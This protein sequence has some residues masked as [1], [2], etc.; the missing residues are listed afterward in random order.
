M[1]FPTARLLTVLELLQSRPEITAS[2]LSRALE[3]N[4]RSIR[5][6][7]TMLQDMGIPVEATRG[8]YGGYH[9]E[10]GFKLPPLMFSDAEV[11]ALTLGLIVIRE[12]QF[13]TDVAAITGALAKLERVMPEKLLD[14]THGLQKS[15]MVNL[16]L[17]QT[18]VN[19]TFIIGLSDAMQHCQR[20]RMMYSSW[21]NNISERLF[22]CYGIVYHEGYWFTTGFCHLR[23]GLRTFRIDRITHLE[24]IDVSY[25]R[26]VDFDATAYVIQSLSNTPGHGSIEVLLK[27]SLAQ[28]QKEVPPEIGT[29]EVVEDGVL[30]RR[31]AQNLEYIARMLIDLSFPIQ[32]IQPAELFDTMQ[33]LSK[34]A[35]NSIKLVTHLT[36]LNENPSSPD[37]FP[38][39]EGGRGV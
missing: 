7:I 23:Q 20:I 11:T 29:L 39:Q 19:N 25:D 1:Y 12:L 4:I 2:E 32:I 8:R 13:P 34:R 18:I 3:V 30:L 24:V 17:P 6:Y 10:R 15:V 16:F 33:A 35:L 31:P 36:Q 26:P 27:T 28:A 38:H 22:D 37:P 14:R 9:L 21:E 5:R